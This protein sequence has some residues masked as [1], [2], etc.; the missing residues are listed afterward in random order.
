M[1]S[2]I[3]ILKYSTLNVTKRFDTLDVVGR[4]GLFKCKYRPTLTNILF[5]NDI[6]KSVNKYGIIL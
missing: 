3:N 5:L 1:K 4:G 2:I 6:V